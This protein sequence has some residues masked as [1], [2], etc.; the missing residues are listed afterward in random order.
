MYINVIFEISIITFVGTNLVAF[1]F[2]DQ[3]CIRLLLV[4]V[5]N[6]DVGT[7]SHSCFLSLLQ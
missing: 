2:E 4:S 1:L 6:L 3:S 7:S 5:L